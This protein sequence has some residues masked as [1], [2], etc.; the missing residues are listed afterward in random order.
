MA[1]RKIINAE[2]GD[3]DD[4]QKAGK[5][6]EHALQ[7]SIKE[8]YQHSQFDT[9]TELERQQAIEDEHQAKIA[10]EIEENEERLKQEI[11]EKAVLIREKDAILGQLGEARHVEAEA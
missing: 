6:N 4:E 8:S 11:D 3:D 7:E 2:V 10:K 9:V 5:L 1:R